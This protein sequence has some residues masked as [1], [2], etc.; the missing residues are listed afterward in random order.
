MGNRGS[1]CRPSFLYCLLCG[2]L[3]LR[4]QPQVKNPPEMGTDRRNA[5]WRRHF[6][7]HAASRDSVVRRA[8]SQV[9]AALHLDRFH[10]PRVPNRFTY[11]ALSPVLRFSALDPTDGTRHEKCGF[12][13]FLMRPKSIGLIGFDRVTASHLTGPADTLRS[14]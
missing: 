8:S 1:W 12:Q 13:R 9:A 6:L 7:L 10:G 2:G 14:E 4:C 3:V 5:I 11:R